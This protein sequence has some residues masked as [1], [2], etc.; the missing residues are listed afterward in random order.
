V[1][2]ETLI[3]VMVPDSIFIS[4]PTVT[5]DLVYDTPPG[6]LINRNKQKL[7]D[8]GAQ[9]SVWKLFQNQWYSLTV[10]TDFTNGLARIP[11]ATG[12]DQ[13]VALAATASSEEEARFFT[14]AVHLLAWQHERIAP[15]A[16]LNGRGTV[17]GR[18]VGGALIVP[19]PADYV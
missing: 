3:S 17:L 18:T 13:V 1:G 7:L 10:L 2:L 19:A 16:E 14:S 4:G 5:R 9:S 15:L 12:R 6:D 8:M 11:V